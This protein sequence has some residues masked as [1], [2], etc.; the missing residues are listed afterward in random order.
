MTNESL[1]TSNE[2]VR[3]LKMLSLPRWA[4]AVI[5]IPMVFAL[6]GA[7]FLLGWAVWQGKFELVT[8]AIS[9]LTIGLPIGLIVVAMVFG[10]GG[11]TKLS[12][13]TNQVL[14]Q[15]VPAAIETNLQ[16]AAQDGHFVFVNL[17]KEVK[18]CIA[19]YSINTEG[20]TS[21]HQTARSFELRIKL[22][23][24]VKKV[25]FVIWLS[26]THEDNL[27]SQQRYSSCFFGAQK[28][29]YI[30]NESP[31]HGEKKGMVGLVFIKHLQDDFLINASERLYFAQ[32]LAFF[33]RGLVS[34]EF[35]HVE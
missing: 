10:D 30:L 26:G 21:D 35:G 28:E 11:A 15:E 14:S 4:K 20:Q 31:I 9:I 18:G 13:I 33:V 32:D 1:Q 24:N 27:A 7:I 17:V 22:E 2:L 23:L 8:P 6:V 25:N 12:E 5:A 34:A 19:E 3:W 16:F 29:G